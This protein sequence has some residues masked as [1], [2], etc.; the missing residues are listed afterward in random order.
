[1][2]ENNQEEKFDHDGSLNINDFEE[3]RRLK[4]KKKTIITLTASIIIIA[5]LIA[6]T[7][8][9]E[10]KSFCFKKRY[11][12]HDTSILR[13]IKSNF[14][15]DVDIMDQYD[16]LSFTVDNIIIDKSRMVIF[17]TIENKGAHKYIEWFDYEVLDEMG[18]NIKACNQYPDYSDID[19][20]KTKKIH[21]KFSLILSPEIEIPSHISVEV[22]IKESQYSYEEYRDIKD[23]NNIQESKELP[24]TWKIDIPIDKELFSK[25]K[26]ISYDINKS[27]E[28]EGQ[29]VFFDKLT[30]YPTTAILDIHYDKN[31]TMKIFSIQ[32]LKL[33]A[34][35]EDFTP[36]LN[37]LVSTN[38]D[39]FTR[40]FY[41]KSS[42]F[43]KANEELYI[44]GNGIKCIEKEKLDVVVDMEN[45]KLL[46][47]PDKNLILREIRDDGD[48]YTIFFEYIGD[49]LTFDFDF[50]NA[51]GESLHAESIGNS[52]RE[53]NRTAEIRYTVPKSQNLKSPITLKIDD[54]PDM[55]V[56]PF[57]IEIK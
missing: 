56:K 1:M 19:L 13:A 40:N 15:Q 27:V 10:F 2:N 57:K 55:I 6:L 26:K 49:G 21:D 4:S 32:D 52:Y 17:Y 48:A 25:K 53:E 41:F 16:D 8:S 28:M 20:S 11:D 50:M 3:D 51:K 7:F 34:G 37:G 44:M 31:N 36:G 47:S 38:P 22:K 35:D 12:I 9:S 54:F 33:V 18:N 39:E 5:L 29:T 46:K 45:N 30:I 14:I 42:Y 23:D 24:Y 43:K